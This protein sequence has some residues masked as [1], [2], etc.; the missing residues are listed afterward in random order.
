MS[1]DSVE[2][3]TVIERIQ[4]EP[5]F[6]EVVLEEIVRLIHEGHLNIAH[7]ILGNIVEADL[8]D[9]ENQIQFQLKIN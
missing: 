7:I 9:Y 5:E 6:R 4:R 8:K 3:K 2:L 1:D